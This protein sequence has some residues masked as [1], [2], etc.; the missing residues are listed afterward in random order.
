MKGQA[1]V[2]FVFA[3]LGIQGNYQLVHC[4]LKSGQRLEIFNPNW[5]DEIRIS[6]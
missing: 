2:Q 3:D 6:R 5:R 1:L 4:D